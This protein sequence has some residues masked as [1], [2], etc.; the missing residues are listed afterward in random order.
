MYTHLPP[1][2]IL[3]TSIS[4]PKYQAL[5]E[6]QYFGAKPCIEAGILNHEVVL[7]LQ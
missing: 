3:I 6:A 1:L 7:K 4:I 5:E 2:A